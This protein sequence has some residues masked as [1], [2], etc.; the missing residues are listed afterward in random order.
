MYRWLT[1]CWT[2]VTW[3]RF[4]RPLAAPLFGGNIQ[5][6]VMSAA[7][8]F[9]CSDGSTNIYT[10]QRW[11]IKGQESM[12]LYAGRSQNWI[13]GQTLSR[14]NLMES[15]TKRRWG[16]YFELAGALQR[17]LYPRAPLPFRTVV[18]DKTAIHLTRDPT[19]KTITIGNIMDKFNLPDLSGAL[20]DFLDRVNNG[21]P[22]SQDWWS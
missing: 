19:M 1:Q 11:R 18:H 12:A 20:A 3:T 7:S 6:G 13:F 21:Q 15:M 14:L 17:G 16:D 2:A 10:S 8:Q 22:F 9:R 4:L 5:L